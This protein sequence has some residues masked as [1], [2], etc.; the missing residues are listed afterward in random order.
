MTNSVSSWYRLLPKLFLAPFLLVGF[1]LASMPVLACTAVDAGG[2]WNNAATWEGCGGGIPTASSDVVINR[3]GGPTGNLTEVTIPAGYSA[4]AASLTLGNSGTQGNQRGNRLIWAAAT[5]SL[6]VSG[7]VTLYKPSGGNNPNVLI[8]NDGSATFGS[9][10]LLKLNES[11]N[12]EVI[13]TGGSLLINGALNAEGGATNAV[14]DM[15]GGAGTLRLNGAF[16][17]TAMTLNPGTASTFIYGGGN[18]TALLGVS[19]INYHNLTFAGSGTKSQ[20]TSVAPTISGTTTVNAGVTFNNSASVIYQGAFVNNGTTNASAAHT[21]NGNFIN[22]GTTSASAAQTYN[23]NFIN[24]GDYSATAAQQYRSNFTNSGAFDSGSLLH[25]FNGSAAQQLNGATTFYQMQLDNNAGLTINDDVTVQDQLSL[26]NGAIITGANTLRV[27]QTGGWS[28]VSR[29]NGW[30][31][32]NLGLWMPTGSQG[33]TFDIGDSS[34]YRPL[35]LTI[36]NVTTAGF[37]VTGI[38]QA[39]GDHPQIASAALNAALSVNRWWSIASEGA[40]ITTMDAAFDYLAG[41]ID[42]GATPAVFNI[43]RFD[44]VW[45]NVTVGARAAT[46]TQG[47]GIT[48]FGQF[49]IAE[50]G[51]NDPGCETLTSG[52]VGQYFNNLTLSGVPAGTRVDGPIDFNWGTAAPGVAGVNEDQFSV[53][54]EGLLRTT[55][56]GN[57]QFQTVSDDGVR[58]W[59]N[60]VLIID[61]WTDHAAT[62]NTSGNVLLAGGQTYSIRLEYYENLV[63]SVIRLR[64]QLPGSGSFV[65]IP[66][67]PSPLLGAGLYHCP[68]AEICASGEP[69]GGIEGDYFS[70]RFLTGSPA[71]TRVDGPINFN[72]A[73]GAPGVGG[74]GADQFSVRWEGTLRATE[75]GNYQFQ[76]VSDDGVR[77]WVNGVQI[78]NNWTNHAATTNTSGNV[79]LV[80]G[81][82][83]PIR[84]EYFE[85]GGQSVIRLRWRIPSSGTYVTIPAGPSPTLGAGLYYCPEAP[86]VAAYLVSHA[87]IGITCEAQPVTVTAVD[88]SNNPIAPA[89]GSVVALSTVPGT[90]VWVDG[91]NYI[92][93]GTESS[94]VKYLQHT[95]QASLTINVTDGVASG[96]SP[97]PIA[98]LDTGLRFY[99]LPAAPDSMVAGQTYN[100]ATV[101][102]VRTNTDT[103]ACETRVTGNR[104]VRLAYECLDPG[105]CSVG[106]NFTVNGTG[107]AANHNGTVSAYADVS[108]SFNAAG[109][110]DIPL[111]F[112]DVGRVRLH[113][114]LQLME[115][116]NEPAITLV[117]SSSNFV[118]RPHSFVITSVQNGSGMN[119]GITTAFNA[120]GEVFRV[121]VQARN[122]SEPPT[123]TPNYGNEAPPQGIELRLDSLTY[124]TAGVLGALTNTTN[125]TGTGGEFEN[126]TVSWD[127]VGTI[128]LNAH[129]AGGSYL[130][131]GD[132]VDSPNVEVGR[133]YPAHFT[134]DSSAASN[135]CD[136][137]PIGRFSYMNHPA[138]N[139]DYQVTARSSA[140]SATI[141]YR[142]AS[143][144]NTAT[145]V[146]VAENNDEGVDRGN[147]VSASDPGWVNGA[148]AVSATDAAFMRQASTA[149]D[150]PFSNL[151]IGIR[152]TDTF[153]SRVLQ[154]LD[155]NATT[156]GVCAGVTCNAAALSSTLNLRFGRLR[157]DDAFGPESVPLPV[158]FVTEYW[159]GSFFALSTSDTWSLVNNTC[160]QIPRSAI[161]YEPTGSLLVDANRT[162]PIGSSNT[163]GNYGN[164]TADGVAFIA[165]NAGHWFSAPDP[166]TGNF[167]VDVDLV[168]LPWL[169]FDWNQDGDFNNDSA[170]PSANIGFGQYRGHDRI[171][172][173]REVFE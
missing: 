127:E 27:A 50:P 35:V 166:G 92:F 143:Y 19:E 97:A 125:F 168:N 148:W 79:A 24:T 8:I 160:T 173:W 59:V 152:L 102:A 51:A 65:A 113:G 170:L 81:E 23:G 151:Q 13:I 78:I 86:V 76:T 32:G 131:T 114:Q 30:V 80:A 36:P 33:R 85:N 62:T 40:A 16:N 63:D 2:D 20:T 4:V 136:N 66:A 99:G 55:Q 107:I 139:L 52:I 12:A 121:V 140:G 75:T 48:G 116:V 57:Y 37:I 49:A 124:P 60:D 28:G 162:V 156:P 68:A 134:L 165:G 6:T 88:A 61:N 42:A 87:N 18:Q 26:T 111:N 104:T 74:I 126:A 133:F 161:V 82:V 31:A 1:L 77:L 119:N 25:T 5:S 115:Q 108:L 109:S 90:G 117:G 145:I 158:T 147:R 167:Q 112:T 163:Q 171:I 169:R 67:G 100:G 138:I 72:W 41:D 159:S 89:A 98:F 17:T 155:M 123:L 106:Q 96:S 93:V 157:L 34:T 10:S 149:P 164:L 142:S 154:N 64:W 69:S 73:G 43:Q 47:T 141:N 11:L 137:P 71:G 122:A 146:Y 44:G 39:N 14:I 128:N 110:A 118:S 150:G 46:S 38:S 129:V 132:V 95:T 144:A 54:W 120:A 130:S 22:N 172:Y 94:F 101:R 7:A 84:L 153:G 83:Y 3:A 70:N 103:G 91:S 9:L 45:N 21:Y 105:T 135:S 56:S 29:G 15:A 53:R 58:L